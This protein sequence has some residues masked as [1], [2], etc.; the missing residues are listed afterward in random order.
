MN[1]INNSAVPARCLPLLNTIMDALRSDGYVVVDDALPAAL[2]RALQ[3]RILAIK[4][5][6]DLKVAGIGRRDDH[7]IARSIRQD[8]IQ[9]MN[10]SDAS[11]SGWLTAMEHLRGYA[12]RELLLGLFE[13]ESHFAHYPP[14][15]GYKKHYDAFK[16]QS[17][18]VLSTVYYLNDNWQPGDGGELAIYDA[19]EDQLITQVQPVLNRLVIFLSEE[20]PHEV[21]P[22]KNHRY[23]IAGWFRVNN[24]RD[25]LSLQA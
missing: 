17:N 16:G 9:W 6:G 20:F 24:S 13:Y 21:L 23:S 8:S 15:A 12:N 7:T 10:R 25:L 18:R 1:A 11:E 14:G 19:E 5:T 3:Q 22:A 4:N 2:S